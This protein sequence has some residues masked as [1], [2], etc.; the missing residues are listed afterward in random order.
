M[1]PGTPE[2]RAMMFEARQATIFDTWS[3]SG[4]C[5]TGSHDIAVNQI[6]VPAEDSLDIFNGR[7]SIA[8]PMFAEPILYFAMHIA[9]VGVGIAQRALDEII[10][11]ACTNKTRLYASA[12]FADSTLFQYRLGHAETTLRSARMLLRN[13]AESVWASAVAGR[14]VSPEERCRVTGTISWVAH[15]SAAVVDVCYTAGGGSSVYHSSQLQR[16]LRDIHTLTQH[17]AAAEAWLVRAGA[18]LVGRMGVRGSDGGV[19]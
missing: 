10:A 9:A 19:V 16:C 18:S 7:S 15:T 8:G 13:E 17:A 12:A 11:L 4:L 1:A 6:V 5:G 3:V 2:L 14:P